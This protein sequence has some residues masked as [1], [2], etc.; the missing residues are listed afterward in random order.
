[1]YRITILG[2]GSSGGVP[3]ADN[4]WG[5]CN[6]NDI[7]NH[8][9]R[10]SIKVERIEDDKSTCV[11]ID[12]SPDLRRQLIESK[13]KTIDAVIYTHDHADQTHGIDDLR[14]IVYSNGSRINCY[15]QKA[16]AEVLISRFGYVFAGHEKPHYPAL[17]NPIELCWDKNF[18]IAGEGGEIEFQPL[19]LIHGA[20]ENMGLRFNNIAYCN[21]VNQISDATLEKMFNLDLLIIDAL[22]YTK[23]P[24]HAHLGQSLEWI[25][26]LKP[27]KAI[28][29]NMHIDMDY[30]ELL[31]KLPENV[32][33]AFDMMEITI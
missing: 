20:I 28:L 29:T 10:C 8:R 26:I 4:S 9:M 22:R 1:M 17:L 12:T 15:M 3:R 19:K 2:C 18:K 6:P 31:G 14:A 7:R 11:I 21:D 5:V 30:E 24:S 32:V 13:T 25:D 33:P 16:T 23:H 27:K